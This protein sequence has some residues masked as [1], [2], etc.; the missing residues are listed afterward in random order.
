MKH[1]SNK[2]HSINHNQQ[3]KIKRSDLIK[4]KRILM[5][6]REIKRLIFYE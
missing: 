6:A 4:V 2:M 3:N 5:F 1:G